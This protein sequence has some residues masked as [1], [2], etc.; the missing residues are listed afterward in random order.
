VA[1]RGGTVRPKGNNGE[2]DCPL[3]VGGVGEVGEHHG[4]QVTVVD[5]EV[6]PDG[7]QRRLAPVVASRW[8]E[9]P[10]PGSEKAPGSTTGSRMGK[11]E[12]QRGAAALPAGSA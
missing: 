11:E 8:M 5:A 1:A 12:D 2:A 3:A 7:G 6:E 4:G 10:A 9:R